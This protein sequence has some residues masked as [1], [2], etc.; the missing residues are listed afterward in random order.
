MSAYYEPDLRDYQREPVEEAAAHLD[1]GRRTIIQCPT[2]GGKTEMA[3]VLVKRHLSNSIRRESKEVHPRALWLTHREELR[4]QTGSRFNRYGV[5]TTDLS[6][7]KPQDR[8]LKR[9]ELAIV[10]PQV[11]NVHALASQ[12]DEH[13]LLVVDEAHHS[14]AATWAKLINEWPGK[15]LGLTATPWRL[16]EKE[17][18]I[19]LFDELVIGPSIDDLCKDNHLAKYVL[20]APRDQDTRVVGGRIH[21]GDYALDQIDVKVL[22]TARIVEMWQALKPEDARTIWY[23]PTV[24]AARQLKDTL[25]S[26]KIQTLLIVNDTEQRERLPALEHFANGEFEHIINVMTLTEGIDVPGANCIVLARPTMSMVVFLQTLGRGLRPTDNK[27]AVLID[28]G[29]SYN[30]FGCYPFGDV[31]WTLKPRGAQTSGEAPMKSCP[32]CD[33]VMYTGCRSCPGCELTLGEECTGCHRF[34]FYTSAGY[35]G[36]DRLAIAVLRG[37]SQEDDLSVNDSTK[38]VNYLKTR[39][40]HHNDFYCMDCANNELINSNIRWTIGPVN[41]HYIE[42]Y[43]RARG[44]TDSI[45]MQTERR[46]IKLMMERNQERKISDLA[47]SLYGSCVSC[48]KTIGYEEAGFGGEDR[49]L[50]QIMRRMNIPAA[51]TKGIATRIKNAEASGAE[52]ALSPLYALTHCFGTWDLSLDT[53]HAC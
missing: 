13:D 4:R 29:H 11:R 18:F 27:K 23:V 37:H 15:V 25:A 8:K 5:D 20:Y 33:A 12:A 7:R 16:S 31:P 50:L 9:G 35:G 47:D 44:N 40:E 41:T 39:I 46:L 48:G 19:D 22:A 49:Y 42:F 53:V 3:I 10:S 21:A 45:L 2:G 1:A 30:N 43:S 51:V 28:L 34:I 17:G 36:E 14:P 6:E 26:F 24:K 32:C 52:N 38:V